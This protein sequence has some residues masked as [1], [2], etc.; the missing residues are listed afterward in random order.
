MKPTKSAI[1]VEGGPRL[2]QVPELSMTRLNQKRYHRTE[3]MSTQLDDVRMN[4]RLLQS[5]APIMLPTYH[6]VL[7]S[8]VNLS[9]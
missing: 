1:S 5:H 3:G 6:I 4:L 7:Y 9:R 8:Q 2:G